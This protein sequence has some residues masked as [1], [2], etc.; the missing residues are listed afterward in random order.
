MWFRLL[1][2]TDGAGVMNCMYDMPTLVILMANHF[3]LE[4]DRP[5]LTNDIAARSVTIVSSE[6][7][8]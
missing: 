7:D 5:M 4:A 6:F 1:T 2:F 3:G 8:V